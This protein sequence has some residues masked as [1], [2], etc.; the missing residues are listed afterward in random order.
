MVPAAVFLKADAVKQ[1][2]TLGEFITLTK[3][4]A[5]APAFTGPID[6][7]LGQGDLIF[8]QGDCDYPTDQSRVVKPALYPAA[9]AGSQNY[10]VPGTGHGINLHFTAQS[11]FKQIQAF[12]KANGL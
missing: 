10:L 7:V 1:T 6:V 2:Y 9:S 8:C 12:V 3:V 5:P 11:A 4:I